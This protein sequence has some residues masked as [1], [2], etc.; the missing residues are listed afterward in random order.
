M[1]GF[2]SVLKSTNTGEVGVNIISTIINNDFKWIFRRNHNEH[3]FG[4][5]GFIDIIT[6]EGAITGQTIA[7]QIKTGVS[8]FQQEE[9]KGFIFNGDRKHLNY[10]SNIGSPVIIILCNPDSNKVYW[11]L[12]DINKIDGND[13]SWKM[14]I[15]KKQIFSQSTKTKL[16]EIVGPPMNILNDIEES[17]KINRQME[18]ADYIYFTIER[19]DIEKNNTDKI[20]DFFNR[21]QLN[22][23]L[24]KATQGKVELFIDGYNNDKRELWE[25]PTVKKY[26]K[27]IEPKIKYWFFFINTKKPSVWLP[28][29]A[30]CLCEANWY[31]KPKSYKV[32]E[33]GKI[34]IDRKL[35]GE[36]IE[37]NF[38]WLNEISDSLNI[39]EEKI[40][41]I[42]LAIGKTL[43]VK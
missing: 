9:S 22:D 24:T 13:K 8:Y 7:I 18:E 1:D 3:D 19:N 17:W 36:F 2:P 28:T 6:N 23:K 26:V 14:V 37:R 39:G 42:S 15:P 31:I 12:F 38:L 33:V 20:I 35:L 32:L 41:T 43:Q 27:R 21:L 5:D 34:T 10:Y 16:L 11:E 29:M 40:K 4:I 30:S 25:I